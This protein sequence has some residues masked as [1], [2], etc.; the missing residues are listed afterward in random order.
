MQVSVQK[1]NAVIKEIDTAFEKRGKFISALNV[2]TGK[3]DSESKD[4]AAI[5]RHLKNGKANLARVL[6]VSGIS[7]DLLFNRVRN[8]GQRANMKAILKA[9]QASDLLCGNLS[10]KGIQRV[11]QCFI[12]ASIVATVHG[13]DYLTTE[14]QKKILSN[15]TISNNSM[16]PELIDAIK[17]YRHTVMSSGRDTQSSQMRTILDNLNACSYVK[18]DGENAIKLNLASPII[19]GFANAFGIDLKLAES[20]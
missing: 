5:T 20:K 19:R 18:I 12:G 3:T 16:K 6:A 4:Y 13:K 17:E 7:A 10:S 2:E 15:A 8:E 9:I 11:T 1:V 14:E